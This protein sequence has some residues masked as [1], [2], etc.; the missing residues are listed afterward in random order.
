MM[1][2]NKKLS[3]E[4]RVYIQSDEWKRTRQHFIKQRGRKCEQCGTYGPV[5]LHHKT[6]KH[7]KNELMHPEDVQLLCNDCH[8][9]KHNTM[10]SIEAK[11]EEFMREYRGDK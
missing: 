9:W 6:Y 3:V 5:E 10:A 7:F 2:N 8:F 1:Y 4:Y 11:L